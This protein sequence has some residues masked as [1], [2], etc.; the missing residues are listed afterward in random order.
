MKKIR[1]SAIVAASWDVTNEDMIQ[2]Y[3]LIED[4]TR[5]GIAACA[6]RKKF[7]RLFEV[8]KMHLK[9]YCRILDAAKELDAE[10]FKKW[11]SDMFFAAWDEFTAFFA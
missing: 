7:A 1:F 6:A 3:E 5:G 4:Y 8:F 9:R 2:I 10:E 11:S